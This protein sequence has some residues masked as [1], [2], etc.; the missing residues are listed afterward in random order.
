M[1]TEGKDD[2]NEQR[3]TIAINTS[4][5][6]LYSYKDWIFHK[7]FPLILWVLVCIYL[8]SFLSTYPSYLSKYDI[9]WIYICFKILYII[10]KM[11]LS[12]YLF[13]SSNVG[14]IDFIS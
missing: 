4:Y 2:T 11:M 14:C 10:Y 7:Y 12:K 1:L 5:D 6:H 13:L 9:Y 3:K 8:P